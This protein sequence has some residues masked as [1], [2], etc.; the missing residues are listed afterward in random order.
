MK[1][2]RTIRKL[3]DELI[4]EIEANTETE[5]QTERIMKA[6]LDYLNA[7]LNNE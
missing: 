2:N 4:Y 1:S 5:W 3:Y 6:L 7:I